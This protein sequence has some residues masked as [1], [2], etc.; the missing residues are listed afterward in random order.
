MI[1]LIY[2]GISRLDYDFDHA[3]GVF[4]RHIESNNDPLVT[5]WL[6]Q[7][8]HLL[9][10]APRPDGYNP[11]GQKNLDP[12]W[13]RRLG[14]TGQDCYDAILGRDVSGARRLDERMHG[15]LGSDSAA[16]GSASDVDRGPGGAAGNTIRDDFPAPCIPVVE[17]DTCSS[18]PNSPSPVRCMRLFASLRRITQVMEVRILGSFD[19]LKSRHMRFLQEAA[20]LGRVHVLLL[21]DQAAEHRTGRKPQFPQDE[22]RYFVE[23]VRYVDRLTVVDHVADGHALPAP[24]ADGPATWVVEHAEDHAAKLA[25]CAAHGLDYVVIQEDSLA[26]FPL[27]TVH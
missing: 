17:V 27:E 6:E 13:I 2:P 23:A 11:L 26:G 7:V 25:F 20:R 22:R 18:F 1:G 14:Q 4:P 16:H 10:V 19:N 21:S 9:P 3:G 5:Q 8:I 15:V 24:Y 12:Q